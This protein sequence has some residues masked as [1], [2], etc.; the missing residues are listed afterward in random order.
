MT[1]SSDSGRCF[2]ASSENIRAIS[3][4][5][6]QSLFACHGGEIAGLNGWINGC[7]SVLLMSNFSYQVA[8]GKTISENKPELV[9][10]KS[11]LTNKSVFPSGG[12]SSVCTS[13][14]LQE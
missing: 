7:I 5:V 6:S 14:G 8:V 11:I 4:N 3:L 12:T 2:A 1:T 10:R 9:M 13:L